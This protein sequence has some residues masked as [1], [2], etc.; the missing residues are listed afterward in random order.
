M[1]AGGAGNVRV[2]VATTIPLTIGDE[3]E[4]WVYHDFG[5]NRDVDGAK[6]NSWFSG[7]RIS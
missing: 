6:E 7:S 4:I 5:A 2:S 3:V 1:D